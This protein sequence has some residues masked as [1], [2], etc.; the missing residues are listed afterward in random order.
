MQY[1]NG[2]EI[3]FSE[4][5][6]LGFKDNIRMI[7]NCSTLYGSSGSPI[8]SRSNNSIIGLHYGSD[9]KIKINLSTNIISIINHIKDYYKYGNEKE[10]KKKLWDYKDS[11]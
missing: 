5:I 9:N 6:I 3:S 1:P 10:I 7:H 4:G 8:I 11:W 2:N